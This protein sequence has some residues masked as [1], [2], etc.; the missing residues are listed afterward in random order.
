MPQSQSPSDIRLGIARGISYGM[1][2]PPE[3]IL[4]P[5]REL[6]AGLVRAYV[7]WSQVEPRPGRY[8][9]GVVDALLAQLSG[10]EEVWVTVC[11]SSPWG[12][13]TATDFLPPSPALDA[14]AYR[15][16]VSALVARCR[17]QV[18]YWQC[19]NEPSN[20]GLL[21][22]GTAGEYAAQL[23]VFHDAV[24]ESD[25]T[26]A[27][28]LGGYGYDGL[29]SPPEGAARAFFDEALS[30]AGASFDLF[31]VHLYDDPTRIP[32]HIA[33]VRGM[34]RRHGFER[35][36]VV[37]EYNGPTLFQLPALD[38]VLQETMAA[39]FAGGDDVGLSTGELA[40]SAAVET[41]ERRA[42]KMLYAAIET[43]P[44]ALQMFMDGCPP[45]LDALRDRINCR[46]IVSRNLFA[47]SE[48]VRR[49]VC[50]QLAPEVGNYEDPFTMMELMHGKLPLIAYEDG[51]LARRRPAADSFRRLAAHLRGAASVTRIEPDGRPEVRAFVVDRPERGA[52]TVVWKDGDLVS[53]EREAP[54][55]LEWTWP[56]DT[57]G[58]SDAFGARV[59]VSLERRRVRLGVSVTPTFLEPAW[60]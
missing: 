55:E 2:G 51:R 10:E 12:T 60:S 1:F 37:G 48:G 30:V 17:G 6:G 47:L 15:R 9:W 36:V 32:A 27:V 46:E 3:P 59:A 25:P 14:G 21:W 11:S 7:Y 49:T 18:R 26:A 24:R 35:P 44:P 40:A 31:D 56:G 39:A 42:L 23:A 34:M 41:P 13:R 4:A 29:S 58:A 33:T 28:V 16:F 20:V 50:W 38:G 19:D 53:G 52:L 43:L 45:E 22:A 5:I 57:V 54:V 8:D